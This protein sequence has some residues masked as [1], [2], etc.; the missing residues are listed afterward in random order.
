M[1]HRAAAVAVILCA[2]AAAGCIGGGDASDP[3]GSAGVAVES[4]V[5]YPASSERGAQTLIDLGCTS[6]VLTVATSLRTLVAALPCDRLPPQ[7]V[8]ERF[9]SGTVEIEINVEA[10]AKLFLRSEGGGSLEFTVEDVRVV[11]EPAD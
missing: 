6:D 11:E 1:F 10:P 3:R 2:L 9:Q 8:I 4:D 7:Q 5:I